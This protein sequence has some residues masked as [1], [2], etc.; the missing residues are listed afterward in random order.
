MKMELLRISMLHK[1][2]LIYFIIGFPVAAL[3]STP[4]NKDEALFYMG[5]ILFLIILLL[6]PR[7]IT[8]A[9]SLISGS[10]DINKGETPSE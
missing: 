8:V 10:D 5:V 6:L 9:K 2:L 7:I 4:G 1:L 3:A